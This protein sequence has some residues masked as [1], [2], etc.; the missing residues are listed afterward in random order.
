MYIEVPYTREAVKA[1]DQFDVLSAIEQLA[2]LEEHQRI[3]NGQL[4]ADDFAGDETER[5]SERKTAYRALI[6]VERSIHDLRQELGLDE[7]DISQQSDETLQGALERSFMLPGNG[8]EVEDVPESAY[9]ERFFMLLCGICAFFTW[10]ISLA[11]TN[12][13]S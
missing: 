8:P 7:P 5:M 1:V 4:T 11:F 10:G 2:E 9:R 12:A 3:L 13:L 6:I